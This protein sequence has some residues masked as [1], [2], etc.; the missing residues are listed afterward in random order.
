[1]TQDFGHSPTSFAGGVGSGE[2]GG[3]V[4]R[5][6]TPA[7]YWTEIASASLDDRLEASGKF[8]VTAAGGG[9][10]VL[11]GW[12]NAESR[13]W[14]TP[15]SLALRIDGN[16]GNFWVFFEYG[17]RELGT[18]GGDTFEGDR[19]QTTPTDPEPADGSV[20][21]W[22]LV[23]TP[24]G[25][26]GDGE[27]QL[28]LDGAT[29]SVA[30]APVHKAQGATFNRFGIVN[31]QTSGDELTLYV[32]DVTVGGRSYDF[33]AKSG[34]E[35]VGARATFRDAAI[36]PYHDFGYSDTA[37]AGGSVGEIGG[38]VWRIE[39][40]N[41]GEAAYYA[42]DVGGLTMDDQLYAAGR[43]AMTRAGADSAVLIG[44]FDSRTF[45]GAPPA[46][47]LGVMVEGPSRVGHYFRPAYSNREGGGQRR[48]S[49]ASVRPLVRVD[50]GV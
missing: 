34:W 44:W 7:M 42:V 24:D 33:A 13:G 48:A 1:M 49:D 11:L 40:A 19:Y 50:P 41:I 29:H 16:G 36:R 31:Q 30:L 22:R 47:F 38:L 45:V 15:N 26:G 4:A 8:A 10:G 6:L 32:D 28:T 25:A 27:I 9:S 37:H 14:R 18:G 12:F 39:E 2:I 20:H 46:S 43:V 17:T 5:S 23:Y 3:T 35:G 21:E